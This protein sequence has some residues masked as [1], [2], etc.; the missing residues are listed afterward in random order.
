MLAVATAAVSNVVAADVV[1]VVAFEL[2]LFVLFLLLLLLLLLLKLL[3]SLLQLLL[4]MLLLL[5]LLMLLLSLLLFVV[6]VGDSIAVCTVVTA[7][8]IIMS[9]YCSVSV[10]RN[11]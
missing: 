2:Q 5:L 1:V 7:V 4:Q 10:L 8:G 6:V 9:H 3:L 11:D